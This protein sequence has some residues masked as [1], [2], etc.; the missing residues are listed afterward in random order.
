MFHRRLTTAALAAAVLVAT[1]PV[2]FAARQTCIGDCDANGEV[3]IT[4]LVTLIDAAL[5]VTETTTCDVEGA[6]GV[7]HVVLAVNH[8]HGGCPLAGTPTPTPTP[9][10][11]PTHDPNALGRRRF[12]INPATSTFSMTVASG[13]TIPL[14]NFVGQSNGVAEHAFLELE[15]GAP[16]PVT[17]VASIDVTSSSDYLVAPVDALGANFIVCLK[18][19][20][21]A[22]NAAAIDC[23]GGSDYSIG[24]H[25]DHNV[26]QLGV[27]G[28][29]AD[30]C[31]AINGVI[32]GGTR[33]CKTGKE[34]AQCRADSDC[35]T[36][37]QAG[38]GECGLAPSA[39]VAP[40]T[41]ATCRNDSNC[42]SFP[43][44]GD[45]QCGQTG[46]HLGVCN[47]PFTPITGSGDTGPGSVT[48]ALIGGLLGL[49]ATLNIEDS[50]PCGDEGPGQPLSFALT[51][52]R[53]Q[54]IIEDTNNKPR[55]TLD[56]A[57]VQATT[58]TPGEYDLQNFSCEQWSN[59]AGP[60]CLGLVAPAYDQLA[61]ADV[62]TTFKLCGR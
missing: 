38:D 19:L 10:R 26:G 21:P 49:P 9:T 13:T 25:G 41:L 20:T 55:E 27:D 40:P 14:G 61:G 44:A 56:F 11:T 17:H 42:D 6:A 53:A 33:L 35:D 52:T 37:A 58:A 54:A 36:S 60:G 62:I 18:L 51:S 57:L 48:F 15:A 39:C 59:A 29:T 8:A 32:E 46:P 24:L 47:G 28:F 23:D 34:L 4:D 3:G 2:A 7:E 43:G 45:G 16:D 30:Q 31:T 22:R 50:L 5:G 1:A 12:E